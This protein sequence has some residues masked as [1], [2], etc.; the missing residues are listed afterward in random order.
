MLGSMELPELVHLHGW[1][2]P[3]CLPVLKG[4]AIRHDLYRHNFVLGNHS[5]TEVTRDFPIFRNALVPKED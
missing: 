4:D 3:R 5:G 2:N 1:K